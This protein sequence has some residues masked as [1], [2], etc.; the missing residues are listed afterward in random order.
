MKSSMK[1]AQYTIFIFEK[2]NTYFS[3]VYA[4]M[5]INITH[6]S[7]DIFLSCLDYNNWVSSFMTPRLLECVLDSKC[8]KVKTYQ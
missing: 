3:F 6:H 7:V 5:D 8:I 4:E 2:N 1:I